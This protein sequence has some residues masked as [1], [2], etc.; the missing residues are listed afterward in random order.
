MPNTKPTFYLLSLLLAFLLSACGGGI[1]EIP[2]PTSVVESTT[3][4]TPTPE[5]SV[6]MPTPNVTVEMQTAIAMAVQQTVTAQA[7]ESIPTTTPPAST[8]FYN[9][10]V[11]NTGQI[12]C[13]NENGGTINCLKTGQDGDHQAGVAW[14]NP[15]LTDNG[16]GTVTDNL[17][18]LI[19]L[20]NA[21]CFGKQNWTNALSSANSLASGSCG[22]SDGSNA[23]DW[24]QPNLRELLSL[25]DYEQSD[26]ALPSGHPFSGVQSN[27]YWSSSTYTRIPADGW[28][29]YLSGGGT[30]ANL[31][32]ATFFVWPV[33]G[34]Q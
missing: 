18:G 7:P 27:N 24:R 25:I 15:R 30:S 26:P 10:G 14:P 9:A 11:P 33:R 34:G 3:K 8:S 19:W 29:V 13:Y 6:V 23:G 5:A 22:L 2:T 32:T 20:K 1:I 16:D 4:A 31:R 21:N 28:Y 17:T 12:T